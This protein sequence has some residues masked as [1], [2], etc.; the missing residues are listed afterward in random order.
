M[1][2]AASLAAG[3]AGGDVISFVGA[4]VPNDA[5]NAPTIVPAH[6]AGDIIVA[7]DRQG[8][9]QLPPLRSGYTNLCTVPSGTGFILNY[10][11]SAIVDTNNSISS[12][13]GTGISPP[14]VCV[15][16]GAQVAPGASGQGPEDVAGNNPRN[17][18]NL[19]AFV[20]SGSWVVGIL[21]SNSGDPVVLSPSDTPGM[22]QRTISPI[23]WGGGSFAFF[24]SNGVLSSFAGYTW[25]ANQPSF[26][27][28]SSAAAELRRI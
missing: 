18:P 21:A 12:I 20:G 15:Y 4:G 17:W 24:D 26:V 28:N 25:N 14:L 10:R 3:A 23:T 19:A 9:G 2:A 1:T 7:V 6:N 11:I 13:S 27:T 16:R 8:S 22:V 5:V